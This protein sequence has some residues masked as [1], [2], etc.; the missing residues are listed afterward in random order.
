[1]NEMQTGNTSQKYMQSIQCLSDYREA[2]FSNEETFDSFM[3]I[4]AANADYF[5]SQTATDTENYFSQF[6]HVDT[7]RMVYSLFI[8]LTWTIITKRVDP[9]VDNAGFSIKLSL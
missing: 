6:T 2:D 4:L 3:Q 1:M 9:L 5:A 7:K 8:N